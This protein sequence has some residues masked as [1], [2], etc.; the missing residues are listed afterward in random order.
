MTL[1]LRRTWS[2]KP[3]HL[4]RGGRDALKSA[5]SRKFLGNSPEG[6]ENFSFLTLMLHKIGPLFLKNWG[7]RI[8]LEGTRP[9]A[10]PPTAD[11]RENLAKIENTSKR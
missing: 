11:A 8:W 5:F 4:S 3:D 10:L 9:R 6:E 2:E 1:L 7:A